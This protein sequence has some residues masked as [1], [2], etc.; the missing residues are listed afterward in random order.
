MKSLSHR[1]CQGF[2]TKKLI[3][4]QSVSARHLQGWGAQTHR[5]NVKG[6]MKP[7]YVAI[8]KAWMRCSGGHPVTL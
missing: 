7:D 1:D 2:V 5:N 6:S 4:L 8:P 3:Y